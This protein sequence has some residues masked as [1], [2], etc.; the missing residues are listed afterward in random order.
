LSLGDT[1]E[2]AGVIA[3]DSARAPSVTVAQTSAPTVV[4]MIAPADGVAIEL[5]RAH[6]A[7]ASGRNVRQLR[8]DLLRLLAALDEA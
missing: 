5:E 3:I 1:A 8:R 6:A 4:H 2:R 7:W